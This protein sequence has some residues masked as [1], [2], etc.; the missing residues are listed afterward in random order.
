MAITL[1]NPL[2][3]VLLSML[4]GV[5]AILMLGL[6]VL[7]SLLGARIAHAVS[8]KRAHRAAAA[9]A[10]RSIVQGLSFIPAV[11]L[12]LN[13]NPRNWLAWSRCAIGRI[14]SVWTLE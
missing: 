7:G 1:N 12:P 3:I 9:R 10:A 11:P 14:S 8:R 5:L 6:L 4:V 13:G 2:L